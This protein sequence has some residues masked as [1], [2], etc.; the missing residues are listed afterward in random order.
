MGRAKDE[1]RGA[2]AALQEF[3][4]DGSQ[5]L[6]EQALLLGEGVPRRLGEAGRGVEE[7][8][9]GLARALEERLAGR[10]DTHVLAR[11]LP[12]QP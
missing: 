12:P 8:V 1:P 10:L 4:A 7:Q 3:L 6:I 11:H 9:T 5:S 2:L